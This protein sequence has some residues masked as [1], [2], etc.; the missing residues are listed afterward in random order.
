MGSG[1]QVW[2]FEGIQDKIDKACYGSWWAH[3]MLQGFWGLGFARPP[4]P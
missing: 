1:L 4:A 3:V 2:G